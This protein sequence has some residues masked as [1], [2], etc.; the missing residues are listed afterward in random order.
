[1]I[2][3]AREL[4]ADSKIQSDIC[5]VGGGPAGIS[6]AR[7]FAKSKYRI[8]LMES[9][10]FSYDWPTQELYAGKVTGNVL[11]PDDAYLTY[12]RLRYFGGS[13]NHWAGYCRPLDPIDFEKKDWVADS[14]WPISWQEINAYYDRA[15]SVCEIPSF[16]YKAEELFDAK[17]FPLLFNGMSDEVDLKIFHFSGPTRFGERYKSEFETSENIDVYLSANAIEIFSPDHFTREIEFACLDNKRFRVESKIFVIACGGIENA[18]LLLA[19][20]SSQPAGLGNSQDLVGRYFMEHPHLVSGAILAW[21][22]PEE[23]MG[24]D[25]K[26]RRINRPSPVKAV[27]STTDSFQKSNQSLAFSAQLQLL[28]K[29]TEVSD[30]IAKASMAFENSKLNFSLGKLWARVE[31]APNPSSR[32]LLDSELDQFG[33]PKA[34]LEWRTL[35]IDIESAQKSTSAI[36]RAMGL[37][38]L[39]RGSSYIAD[40]LEWPSDIM[41][42]SHHMGTTK[43]GVSEKNAV[44]DS[45][46]RLFASQNLFV[47]GS[48]VFPTG[49]FANP[50]L[51]IVALS[52]RLADTL[53]RELEI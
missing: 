53:K 19:S 25:K 37:T 48:S 31:Q 3:D 26:Y 24:F 12:S 29:K 11:Q 46:C 10:G 32:V 22:K 16:A 6:L 47:A 23:L 42:G 50:T 14:G 5:I 20:N 34:K 4:K 15:C 51:S 17:D 7:E 36:A 43:M 45:D 38:A 13:S 28:D 49:G 39:G 44:V 40:S 52:I 9:G 41:A 21:N 27:F 33:K 1:M 18:R 35:P 30:S 2:I 8:V